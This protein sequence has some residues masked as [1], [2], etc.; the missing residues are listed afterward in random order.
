MDLVD[1]LRKEANLPAE[2][3]K[4]GEFTIRQRLL[5][6]VQHLDDEKAAYEQRLSELRAKRSI[7]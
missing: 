4:D 2:R 1:R 3:V 7:Q 6:A 5:A